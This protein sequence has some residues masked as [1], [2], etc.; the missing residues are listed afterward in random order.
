MP[1]FVMVVLPAPPTP[2]LVPLMNFFII[3]PYRIEITKL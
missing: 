3:T 1:G 2:A